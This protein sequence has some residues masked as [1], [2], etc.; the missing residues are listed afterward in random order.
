MRNLIVAV[1]PGGTTGFSFVEYSDEIG[2][3]ATE[4]Q[5]GQLTP[6]EFCVWLEGLTMQWGSLLHLVVE[7]FTISNRT[8]KVSR[9][10][11]YDALEVI[12]VCR[13]LSLRDCKRDL[14]MSQPSTVMSL[15]PDKW[16]KERGWY[17]P[18]KGH[19]NDSLRH[20]ARACARRHLIKVLAVPE[21]G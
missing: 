16:L 15:F 3:L 18:G 2:G 13:Y 17:I 10:G 7:R 19:A 11:S 21:E 9:A 8:L 5:G 6:Q 4:P 20:L 1:D 14:E 12:G